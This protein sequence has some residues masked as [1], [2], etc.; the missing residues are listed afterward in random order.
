M[1]KLVRALFASTIALSLANAALAADAPKAEEAAK[2]VPAKPKKEKP[3]VPA[4]KKSFKKEAAKVN[5]T[6]AQ[7]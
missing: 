1:H 2:T 3:V 4:A 7:K 6:P 5:A